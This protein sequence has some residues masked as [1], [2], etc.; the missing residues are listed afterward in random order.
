MRAQRQGPAGI[1]A[2]IKQHSQCIDSLSCF[3]HVFKTLHTHFDQF[4][5]NDVNHKCKA[6]KS[7]TKL[8]AF[9]NET[10]HAQYKLL[11]LL[12]RVL[13][14]ESNKNDCSPFIFQPD[15]LPYTQNTEDMKV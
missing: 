7:L 13:Q 10:E 9:G 5:L 4:G 2:V 8:N 6:V 14:L 11:I 1:V 3:Y 15:T 12:C